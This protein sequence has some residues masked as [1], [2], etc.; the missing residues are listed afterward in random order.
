MVNLFL[1]DIRPCPKGFL[2]ARNAK[3][4]IKLL[5]LK[6]IN[7]LSLD[8]DLGLGQPTGYDVV[9]YMVTHK[10]YAKQIIIHSANPFGR[11][12]MFELLS[13]HLPKKVELKIQPLP[14][15]SGHQEQ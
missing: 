15:F 8:H 6:K 3:E 2:L 10:R 1:D 14:L 5:Q 7:I 13:H 11:R 12:R 4:C 9:Q